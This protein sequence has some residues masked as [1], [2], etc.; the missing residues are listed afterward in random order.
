MGINSDTREEVF[1]ELFILIFV[2]FTGFHTWS[3]TGHRLTLLILG[4]SMSFI[5]SRSI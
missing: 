2:G 3:S 1:S 5:N 4:T